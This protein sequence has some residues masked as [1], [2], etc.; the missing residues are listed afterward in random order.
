MIFKEGF[1]FSIQYVQTTNK[2]KITSDELKPGFIK[3]IEIGTVHKKTM[4]IFYDDKNNKIRIREVKSIENIL[5]D[6][7]RWKD[8]DLIDEVEY[9]E[10]KKSVLG[11][12][13]EF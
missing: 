10:L 8:S 5:K 12:G 13:L 6:L 3:I 9:K 7:K 2:I 4:A 1:P 11:Y